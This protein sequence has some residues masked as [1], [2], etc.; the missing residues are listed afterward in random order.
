MSLLP[1][2]FSARNFNPRRALGA[3]AAKPV[4]AAADTGQRLRLGI[5]GLAAIF[6]IVLIAAAG[7]R[8]AQSVAAPGAGTEP[9]AQLGVAPSSAHETAVRDKPEAR[10]TR[11]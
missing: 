11:I 7:L 5:T 8:P 3:V 10:P 1:R 9:L 4:A 6:L 2:T